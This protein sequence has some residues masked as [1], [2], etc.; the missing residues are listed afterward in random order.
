MN[1]DGRAHQQHFRGCGGDDRVHGCERWR[2]ER[3]FDSIPEL[4]ALRWVA[5]DE[6]GTGAG[7]GCGRHRRVGGLLQYAGSTSTP[8]GVMVSHGNVMHNLAYGT[9]ME[10]VPRVPVPVSWLP[11]FHDFGLVF[12][13]WS[14]VCWNS[15]AC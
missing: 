4:K 2:R 5:T 9:P 7:D 3:V 8:K 15:L 12:G 10:R 14:R 11:H 1:R 13:I 6:L